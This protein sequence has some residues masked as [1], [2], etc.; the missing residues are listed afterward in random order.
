MSDAPKPLTDK[1]RGE[2]IKLLSEENE[3]LRT[4]ANEAEAD[5]KRLVML[6][7][8]LQAALEDKT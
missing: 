3:Q 6:V 8:E 2:L 5:I 4:E 7:K 1:E